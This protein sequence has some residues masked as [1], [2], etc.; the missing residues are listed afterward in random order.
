[1]KEIII[2]YINEVWSVRM[3]A[4]RKQ[5]DNPQCGK[6]FDDFKEALIYAQG[7]AKEF[8]LLNLTIEV[9]K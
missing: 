5:S 6:L 2:S 7:V 9:R 4:L 1:M 3:P 8:N